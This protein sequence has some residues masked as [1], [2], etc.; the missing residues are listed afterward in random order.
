MKKTTKD[1]SICDKDVSAAMNKEQY[2]FA[3][4]GW[5]HHLQQVYSFR[6]TETPVFTQKD[7][8]ITTAENPNHRQGYDN[9]T[10]LSQKVYSAGV[11]A[12][13]HC[14]FDGS[15]C[16]ALIMVKNPEKYS[17][18]VVRYEECFEV[19]LWKNGVNVWRYYIDKDQKCRWHRRL[20]FKMPVQEKDIHRLEMLVE[21]DYLSFSLDGI[22]AKLRAEDLFDT[23]YLGVNACEGIV[24]FYDLEIETLDG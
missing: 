14:A 3:E 18:G 19:V 5:K 17:D 23:F 9:I 20:E 10:M 21:K 15:G 22:S 11:K 7:G 16:P 1:L 4:E 2:C 12:T 6:F 8:Y 13:T 24:R